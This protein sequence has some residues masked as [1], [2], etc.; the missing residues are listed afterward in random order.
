MRA[1]LRVALLLAVGCGSSVELQ[2][3]E[4]G[5]P[6]A[7]PKAAAKYLEAARLIDKG[8]ASEDRAMKLMRAALEI[9]GYLWEAHYNLG[10]I[11]RRR[12]RL[13]R[14]L[15]HFEAAN[16]IQ[17]AA[18]EP[19]I[20]LAETRDQIGDWES[21]SDLLQ[22]YLKKKPNAVEARIALVGILRQHKEY[23]KAL[24][25]ARDVLVRDSR[26]SRALLEVGRVY[27]ARADLDVAEL[28]FKKALVLDDKGPAP[29]NDLGL[30]ALARGDT[31]LAFQH[32]ATAVETDPAYAPAR[33]NRAS[34]LLRA[35]DY[36]AAAQEYTKVLGTDDRHREARIGLGVALRGQGKHAEALAEYKRVLKENPGH[37]PALFNMAI[38][39]TE[40][41]HDAKHAERY[42]KRFAEAYARED[43][44][45]SAAERYLEDL[46]MMGGDS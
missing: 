38:L 12:G 16:G 46:E 28:V 31:Q 33:L 39:Y 30:V 36:T 45:T 37:A 35:G 19:I 7:N 15:E 17:P 9:D 32:F 6:P 2:T 26:N 22:D 44:Y 42:F 11:Y 20:A 43:A 8:A 23:R 25:Q 5:L 18:D 3:N 4:A 10:V 24:K 21:A 1:L 40:F 41:L 14:A 29:H 34:V 27:L 13:L